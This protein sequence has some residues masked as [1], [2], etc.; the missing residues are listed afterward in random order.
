MKARPLTPEEIA[1]VRAY[2]ENSYPNRY[3]ERDRCIFELGING[4]LRVSELVGLNVGQVFPY[5]DLEVAD[6]LELYVT[7]GNRHRRVPLNRRAR[8][9]LLSFRAWEADH[10]ESLEPDAPLFCNHRGGRLTRQGADLVLKGIFRA[11]R[12]SG[13][14]TTHSLRKTFATQLA[15]RGVPIRVIQELL[16]HRSLNTTEA[17]VAVTEEDKRRAVEVLAC[18]IGQI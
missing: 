6:S 17:Y 7:K 18:A 1:C 10:G 14:V 5:G 12:L 3:R 15:A 8:S 4:G 2:F 11:C 16:G 13:K 9:V